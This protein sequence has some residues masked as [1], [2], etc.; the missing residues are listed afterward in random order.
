MTDLVTLIM[1]AATI[2][3][4]E[5]ECDQV[6]Q[7]V[8]QLLNEIERVSIEDGRHG[9]YRERFM[10]LLKRR[11]EIVC[12]ALLTSKS[13]QSAKASRPTVAIYR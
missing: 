1:Q 6:D 11:G 7:E 8:A 4:L 2:S 13:P 3:R 5:E 10:A 12:K 9:E